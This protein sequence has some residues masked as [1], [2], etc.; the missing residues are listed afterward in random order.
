MPPRRR[1]FGFNAAAHE[2]HHWWRSLALRWGVCGLLTSVMWLGGGWLG[3][4]GMLGL[5]LSLR[6]WA[7]VLAADIMALGSWLWHLVRRQAFK[8][9]E[10]RFYQF[11]GHRIRVEDDAL[12]PLRW[13]SLDDLAMALGAPI[14]AGVLERR[15]PEALFEQRH[16]LYVRDDIVLTWLREQRSDR[17]GRLALWVERE[18]W[19]PAR[20]RRKAGEAPSRQ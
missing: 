16:G 18:V 4:G 6:L 8:P 10:G 15:A 1:S 9:V 13:L 2:R 11:K 12:L 3:V 20:G 19:Y 5:L 14:S 7:Q 17:A